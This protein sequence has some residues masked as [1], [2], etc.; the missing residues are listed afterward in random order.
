M[1]G[2]YNCAFCRRGQDRLACPGKKRIPYQGWSCS[3]RYGR[4]A[5]ETRKV[6]ITMAN[7][8]PDP[9]KTVFVEATV[10]QDGSLH[11]EGPAPALKPGDRVRLTISPLPTAPDEDSQPLL[12]TVT[13]YDDPFGPAAP[14][15]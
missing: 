6:G 11:L 13:R 15:E 12:D 3:V 1:C 14:L 9:A 5:V 10:A 2:Q 7:V 4:M 8:L